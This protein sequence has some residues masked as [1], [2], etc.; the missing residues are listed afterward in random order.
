MTK[1]ITENIAI[2]KKLL[3]IE[4]WPG[5]LIDNLSS[6]HQD[7]FIRR[8]KAVELYISNNVS[9]REISELT[10]IERHEITRLVKRCLQE[11]ENGVI[12]GYRALIPQKR[13]N[14]YQRKES[15][16]NIKPQDKVNFTGAF[17]QLLSMYPNIKEKL[18]NCYLNNKK[19]SIVEPVI[20]VK[21]LHKVFLDQC[22]SVGLKPNDYPF[23]TKDMGLRS[24]YRL[25]KDFER[26]YF[27][28]SAG[29]YSKDAAIHARVTGVG[30]KSNSM[31]LQPFQ[32]VEFDGHR[33]DVMI[34][35]TYTNL[36]GDEI[37]EVLDRIW[38]LAIIDV[39]TKMIL[40][41]HLCIK[42][43]YS[44]IDV[45]YCIKNA[46]VPKELK[47]LTIPGL[48]LPESIGF[49][50]IAIPDTKWALWEEFCYD[51]AKSNLSSHV[52]SKLTRVIG[53][54]VNAGPVATPERRSHIERLF[55]TLEEN[56]Y[57]R[58]PSTTGSNPSDPRRQNPNNK[59]LHYKISLEH[60]EELTEVFIANYNTTP[61]G[62]INMTPLECMQQRIE[63]GMYP[64]CLPV[65]QQNDFSFL[66]Y[67]AKREVKG[68]L[69]TGKRP[70]INYEGVE[71]RNDI[72]SRSPNLVGTKLDL[73]I[74]L[75]D[76]RFIKAFLPDGS[77]FG[78]LTATG[79]WGVIPHSLQL[80]KQINKLVN[81]KLIHFTTSDDP[82]EI[83]QRYLESELKK[84]KSARN[85]MAE[86]NKSKKNIDNN[87]SES[88]LEDKEISDNPQKSID[89]SETEILNIDF[90]TFT[91]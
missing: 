2:D 62:S 61:H 17:N 69:Q 83:Y 76:I 51:N 54:S 45:L 80:R 21:Y 81:R 73:Q 72:L 24:I 75:E 90:K 47:T 28:K 48:N 63:R 56:G 5:V 59:A 74:N 43:E 18:I 3:E 29:R 53:C 65:E 41:Y 64:R 6:E 38:L 77:E 89:E 25:K 86:L 84:S 11:D 20:K 31:I 34:V 79:K 78:L 22:R 1:H 10:K 42:K 88:N 27:N 85:K 8:K 40:G 44:A 12:W 71:Y 82:I 58:L 57:H 4:N 68:N 49:H 70:Y 39:A 33:L 60:L 19:N 36:E 16:L 30:Q 37:V 23:T 15:L 91:Y 50:S 7:I 14:K 35:L 32:R 13:V 46:I 26:M 87:Q 67:E 9:V 52:I 66:T 55:E